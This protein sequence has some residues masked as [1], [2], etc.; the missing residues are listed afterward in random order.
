[1][2]KRKRH[3]KEQKEL[4]AANERA[5]ETMLSMVIVLACANAAFSLLQIKYGYTQVEARAFVD[6]MIPLAV[7][8]AADTVKMDMT[9]NAEIMAELMKVGQNYDQKIEAIKESEGGETLQPDTK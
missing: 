2:A 3:T 9:P 4:L 5:S 1:M 7:S 6:E 8:I